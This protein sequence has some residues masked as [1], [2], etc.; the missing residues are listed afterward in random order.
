M[1]VKEIYEGQKVALAR[2]PE[3]LLGE[4]IAVRKHG[5]VEVGVRGGQTI[6]Y[7]TKALV[8]YKGQRK[9]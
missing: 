6:L 8:E 7:G 9:W 3:V 4:V 1:K 5:V 2:S